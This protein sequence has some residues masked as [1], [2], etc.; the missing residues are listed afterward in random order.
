MKAPSQG[1]RVRVDAQSRLVLPRHL[2]D[3]I[4]DVPG[5]VIVRHTPDG[6]LISPAGAPGEVTIG[7]DGLPELRLG[8]QVTNGQVL[9]ALDRE[10]AER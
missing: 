6:L 1:V 3:E 2:R 7:S 10:R 5:D 9:A 4:I 8:R